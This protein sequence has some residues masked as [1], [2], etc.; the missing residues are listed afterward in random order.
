MRMRQM[1]RRRT[2]AAH[3][4]PPAQNTDMVLVMVMVMVIVH[5]KLKN[6]ANMCLCVCFSLKELVS[7]QLLDGTRLF[8]LA[9]NAIMVLCIVQ[10]SATGAIPLCGILAWCNQNQ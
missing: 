8:M 4:E 9:Q 7:Y 2:P 1:R 10:E 5:N 6:N 3:F